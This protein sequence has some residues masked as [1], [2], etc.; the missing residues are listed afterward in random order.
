VDTGKLIAAA[1]APDLKRFTL[2]LG[3]NDAAIVLPDADVPS[4]G[5]R[6]FRGAFINNGQI[7][8]GIK[9][10]LVPEALHDDLVG[11]LAEWARKVRVGAGTEPRVQLGPSTM[12]R[13]STGSARWWL[14]L[15]RGSQGRRGRRPPR[16]AGLLFR[17][18]D[19]GRVGRGHPDR[20]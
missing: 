18:D 9:R 5:R 8:A 17:P 12:L 14:T 1:A 2:E 4:I 10:V 6:L 15:W 7:C 19:P 3:G 13:S 20:R 11:C 16:P